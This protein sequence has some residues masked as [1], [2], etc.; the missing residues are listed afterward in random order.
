MSVP[1]PARFISE[2]ASQI[3]I[4]FAIGYFALKAM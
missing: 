3:S 1:P 2:A 4:Q